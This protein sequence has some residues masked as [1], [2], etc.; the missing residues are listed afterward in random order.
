M[1]E[2]YFECAQ[3]E[4]L[5][6][7]GLN[8]RAVKLIAVTDDIFTEKHHYITIF[9]LCTREDP[10]QQPEALE[11]H[12]CDSWSWQDW[13][14]VRDIMRRDGP[15]SVFLPIVNLLRDHPDIETVTSAVI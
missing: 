13:Q 8:V 10:Q 5:E 3:R 6:E 1:G 2:T 4:V 9:V 11:P 14:E 12:K 15:E 7:T